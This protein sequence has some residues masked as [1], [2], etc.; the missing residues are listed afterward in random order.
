MY[1]IMETGSAKWVMILGGDVHFTSNRDDATA[2]EKPLDV[3]IQHYPYLNRL[4]STLR[5]VETV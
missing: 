1:N 2:F 3:E 4:R 5:A